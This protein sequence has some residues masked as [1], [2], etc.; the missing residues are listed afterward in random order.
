[1]K[2]KSWIPKIFITFLL[3]TAIP[4]L[5]YGE[6][7]KAYGQ[8][9]FYMLIY[10]AMLLYSTIYIVY[11]VISIFT[12]ADKKSYYHE[13]TS[14]VIFL[15]YLLTK[16]GWLAEDPNGFDRLLNPDNEMRFTYPI[17]LIAVLL[18]FFF[19]LKSIYQLVISKK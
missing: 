18:N 1:M 5:A 2:A 3:F 8:G 15:F 17:F 6:L 19:W 16:F 12:K 14:I 9:I 11:N 7:T 13:A 4:K 10:M